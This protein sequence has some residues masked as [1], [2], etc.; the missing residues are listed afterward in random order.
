MSTEDKQP[1]KW[2]YWLVVAVSILL[3]VNLSRGVWGLWQARERVIKAQQ[4]V[5]NLRAEKEKLEED[6]KY[7]LS[8]EYAEREI[9]DKLNLAKPGE[10][11]LIIPPVTP[12]A[13]PSTILTQPKNDFI[14]QP[15]WRRWVRVILNK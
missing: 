5:D 11:V 15:I 3:M 14:D 13:T 6:L 8:D 12:I 9:R 1:V 10:T 4:K 2:S 7:Q